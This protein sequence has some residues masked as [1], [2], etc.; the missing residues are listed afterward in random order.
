VQTDE[1]GFIRTDDTLKTTAPGIWAAGDVAGK[2]Q[3]THAAD[4]MGRIAASNAL[5]RFRRVAPRKFR[6]D[7]IP[8]VTYTQPEV[9]RIGL[10]EDEAIEHGA[11]VAYIPMTDVD[12]AITS[13]ATAGFVKLLAGPRP[14][15]RGAGGGQVLGATIVAARAGEMIHEAALAMRTHMFTGRLA[16]T[17][18]AYPTWSLALRQAAAQFFV[19]TDGRTAR[20]ARRDADPELAPD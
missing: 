16:Q 15:L 18:H 10:I 1:R 4:E 6:S 19:E 5:H 12:R 7:W 20:P 2:L 11:R 8:A 3:F 14:L 9:A 17:V 13:G